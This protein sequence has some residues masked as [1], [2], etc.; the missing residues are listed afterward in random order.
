VLEEKLLKGKVLA[1]E[2]YEKITC[3]VKDK[4]LTL[5]TIVVGENASSETYLNAQKRIT[6]K[7]GINHKITR[8]DTNISEDSLLK[9]IK[10]INIADVTTGVIIQDPLPE[11]L[12]KD[13]LISFL[14]PKKDVEGIHPYNIGK[15]ALGEPYLIPCTAA[16]VCN[17]LDSLKINYQGIE[18]VIVGHSEIVGKPLALLLVDRLATV[19]ICHIG[20]SIRGNL[21]KHVSKAEILIVAVGKANLIKGAWLKEDCIVIDVGINKVGEKIVGD[22]EFE[23]ALDKAKYITPVPGGVGPLTVAMLMRNLLSCFNLQNK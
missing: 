3:E 19:T 20:T 6:Q 21:E 5:E 11:H 17:L 9:Y 10:E 14:E 22:V 13:K 16:A 15:L 18:V 4:N 7:L 2:I 1:K 23:K 12:V 8:F